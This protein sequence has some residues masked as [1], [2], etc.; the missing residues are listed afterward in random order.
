MKKIWICSIALA[1]LGGFGPLH[2]GPAGVRDDA[3]GLSKTSVFADPSPAAFAYSD[4]A[5]SKSGVLPRAY[6]GAPPQIP[7]V[8]DKYLPIK[9]DENA[10]LDCHE[11]PA[12][13]GRKVKGKPTPMPE[14][15]YTRV[16]GSWQ[17]NNTQYFCTQC[18]VPQANVK[19]LVGNTFRPQ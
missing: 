15:H 8:I 9:A 14:S 3:I 19:E 18:H 11:K 13:M 16:D 7:H 10:C 17:R 4:K 12:M 1:G 5:P 6:A 2:A